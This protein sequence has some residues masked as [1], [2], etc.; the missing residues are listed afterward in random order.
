VGEDV[1]VWRLGGFNKDGF[2]IVAIPAT[3][4]PTNIEPQKDKNIFSPIGS[5][6]NPS[7]SVSSFFFAILY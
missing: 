3:I 2:I 1:G 6:R 4:P 5:S 7:Q